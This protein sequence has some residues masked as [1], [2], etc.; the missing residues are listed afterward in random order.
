[1][2]IHVSVYN[3][4]P[5]LITRYLPGSRAILENSS[6]NSLNDGRLYASSIQPGIKK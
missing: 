2:Y 4:T 5:T 3:I 6:A 1:M